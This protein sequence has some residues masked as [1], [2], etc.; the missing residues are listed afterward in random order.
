MGVDGGESIV[1]VGTEIT[2]GIVGSG[3][4]GSALGEMAIFT[5]TSVATLMAGI[6]GFFGGVVETATGTTGGVV[7]FPV[8][9][10]I[11]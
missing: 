9:G 3:E 11:I 5:E 4:E 2:S 1:E 6:T 8:E 7:V 10:G